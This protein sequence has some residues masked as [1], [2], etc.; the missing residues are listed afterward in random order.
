MRYEL[1]E[2]GEFRSCWRRSSHCANTAPDGD[3][4]V[5][6]RMPKVKPR[7]K[8]RKSP[9]S[10]PK[11]ACPASEQTKEEPEESSPA[12]FTA[13][14][15]NMGINLPAEGQD[16]I[17]S[18]GSESSSF[19]DT[20]SSTEEGFSD[21]S[22]PEP[23]LREASTFQHGLPFFDPSSP[24]DV[25]HNLAQKNST[26]QSAN[27]GQGRTTFI[28]PNPFGSAA[29]HGEAQRS[30]P[31][32]DR[33]HFG[34]SSMQGYPS[35]KF[36]RRPYNH[37][38]TASRRFTNPRRPNGTLTRSPPARPVAPKVENIRHQPFAA[39]SSGLV[40]AF[41]AGVDYSR[42]QTDDLWNAQTERSMYTAVAD[43]SVSLLPSTIGSFSSGY[44][45]ASFSN[46][47]NLDT[48]NGGN[49]ALMQPCHQG[50]DE[51]RQRR[52]NIQAIGIPG[53]QPL[54]MN[55]LSSGNPDMPNQFLFTANQPTDNF[56][57]YRAQI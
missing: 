55:T 19:A 20:P 31:F 42:W 16:T 47:L 38:S 10:A 29:T 48:W 57:G 15:A 34:S 35:Q 56:T 22:C 25:R 2:I 32:R 11:A 37:Q 36:P 39:S 23:V 4:L 54:D 7:S 5:P 49:Q 53:Y 50:L 41:S 3:T 13:P 12:T 9:K 28:G 46:G 52:L 40:G 8:V 33:Y 43:P 1:G 30:L 26:Q 27:L 45:D 18:A 44:S 14:V 6:V 21:A 17:S 24:T 51:E